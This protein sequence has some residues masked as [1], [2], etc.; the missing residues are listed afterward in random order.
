MADILIFGEPPK[1]LLR[2]SRDQAQLLF[3]NNPVE[4]KR[5]VRVED[6]TLII[7]DLDHHEKQAMELAN[8]IRD[9]PC[10]SMTPIL[11]LSSTHIFEWEAFHHIHC[12][13]YILKPLSFQ[14]V[15]EIMYLCIQCLEPDDPEHIIVFS[16][17]AKQYPVN[18]RDI[19][20]IDCI[21]REVTVHTTTIELRVPSL[22]LSSFVQEYGDDFLQ[23]H[24]SVI[25]NR[26]QIRCIDPVDALIEL[27][28][29]RD[30]LS[31]GKTY[32]SAVRNA[33]DGI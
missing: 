31:I 13:N 10:Q 9:V 19:L 15:M 27:K 30:V 32:L 7:I 11:I 26:R 29:C 22:R 25:V 4:V 1:G 6:F 5:R 14:D 2:P 17:G 28:N 3:T 18:I 21:R 23:I 16:C 12:Y 33:F 8:Y 24:R 20:Y